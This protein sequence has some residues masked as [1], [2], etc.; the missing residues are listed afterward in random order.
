MEERILT[1]K[2][3]GRPML[4]TEYMA[5]PFKNT[6][7]EILPLLEKYNVGA[8]NWGLV[9]GKTQTHCPWD[10]W[11]TKYE[12]EPDLWFHDIF[13]ENGEPYKAEEVRFLKAFTSKAKKKLHKV[14]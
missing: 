9:A 2:R 12:R 11:N 1:L 8:Y 14:A 5:R 10:S 7:Q 4:C 13:R 6:F 3:F